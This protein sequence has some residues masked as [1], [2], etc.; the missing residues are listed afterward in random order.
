MRRIRYEKISDYVYRSVQTFFTYR[1]TEYRVILHSDILQYR[2]VN[3]LKGTSI[4][5]PK[6][7]NK[8]L[9]A[10][11]KNAKRKLIELGVC[12]DLELRDR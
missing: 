9:R 2:I 3:V 1:G 5:N 6:H 12:F 10:L 11:K 4:R 7:K 8:N